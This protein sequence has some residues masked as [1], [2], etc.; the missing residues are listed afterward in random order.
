MD[1]SSQLWVE[2]KELLFDY[3]SLVPKG[4]VIVEIGTAQGGSSEIFYNA[5]KDREIEIW[6]YDIA[7]SL[8]AYEKLRHT[9]VFIE[10]K[11]SEQGAFEWLQNGKKPIDFLFIDG[12][13]TLKDVFI[14]YNLWSPFLKPDGMICFHDYDPPTKCETVHLGV[15]IVVDSMLRLGLIENPVHQYRLITGKIRDNSIKLSTNDCKETFKTILDRVIRICENDK[16]LDKILKD[17][18]KMREMGVKC[19]EQ[20]TDLD[21]CYIINF[22][23]KINR[24]SIFQLTKNKR[25]F[26]E[27]EEVLQMFE[28]SL[29]DNQLKDTDYLEDKE[30][31]KLSSQVSLEQ[32]RLKILSMLIKSFM[33]L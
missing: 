13:H 25:K 29:Y 5:T 27:W 28:H 31:V 20:I 15:R 3:A 22:G 24:E 23:L 18:I 7:P 19:N 2:E 1:N 32:V 16:N 17:Y 33:M 4:G 11:S 12:S 14:D 26:F 9:M 8:E 30:I 6:S 21:A 10:H